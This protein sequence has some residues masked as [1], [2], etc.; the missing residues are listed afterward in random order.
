MQKPYKYFAIHNTTK[1]TRYFNDLALKPYH[2]SGSDY[3]WTVWIDTRYE[4]K[5]RLY[6]YIHKIIPTKYEPYKGTEIGKS[7]PILN[8]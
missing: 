2:F 4:A 3:E 6:N 7:L 5:L 8:F 1:E